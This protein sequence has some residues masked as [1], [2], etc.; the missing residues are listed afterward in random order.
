[1]SKGHNQQ[2]EKNHNWKGGISLNKYKYKL[3]QKKKFPRK[4][5]ARD[6][7]YRSRRGGK[8]QREPCQICGNMKVDGHHDDYSKPLKVKWLCRIHHFELH[9]N[10]NSKQAV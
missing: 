1:M 5:K 7:L 6:I 8:I 10:L 2:M 9:R 3:I 4:F